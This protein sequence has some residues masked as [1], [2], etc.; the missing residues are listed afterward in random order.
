MRAALDTCSPYLLDLDK[1]AQP[2]SS[3]VPCP[4]AAQD[5][6]ALAVARN[7][8]LIKNDESSVYVDLCK[9]IVDSIELQ[10]QTEAVR[11]V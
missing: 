9:A 10:R 4:P 2:P 7:P 8:L 1:T 3:D 11:C 6:A 5:I